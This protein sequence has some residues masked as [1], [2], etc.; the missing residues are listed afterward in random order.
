MIGDIGIFATIPSFLSVVRSNERSSQL[1]IYGIQPISYSLINNTPPLDTVA[2]VAFLRLLISNNKRM[3]GVNGIRSL[4]TRVS[5]LLSSITVFSDSIH[6]GSISPSN[7]L[8][9]C[10]Y[11]YLYLSSHLF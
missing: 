4:L 9:L 10:F 5:T 7:I 6:S 3:L 11:V 8:H 1:F 2:G